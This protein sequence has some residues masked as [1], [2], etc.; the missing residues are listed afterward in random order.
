MWSEDKGSN[1]RLLCLVC[2]VKRQDLTFGI[3]RHLKV[4]DICPQFK[5]FFSLVNQSNP[6]PWMPVPTLRTA[7]TQALTRGWSGGAPVPA[8]PPQ[9]ICVNHSQGVLPFLQPFGFNSAVWLLILVLDSLSVPTSTPP[10]CFLH[11]ISGNASSS[12]RGSSNA[13]PELNGDSNIKLHIWEIISSDNLKQQKKKIKL[14][15]FNRSTRFN[16][17]KSWSFGSFWKP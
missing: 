7:W 4:C 12:L 11:Q 16:S 1:K 3:L 15:N 5:D 6:V 14:P 8:E 10:R 13:I 9:L 17:S 2:A